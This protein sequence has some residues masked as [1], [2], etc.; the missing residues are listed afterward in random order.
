MDLI[1][2]VYSSVVFNVILCATQELFVTI[3]P[4]PLK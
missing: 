1:L 4:G 2:E 3:A